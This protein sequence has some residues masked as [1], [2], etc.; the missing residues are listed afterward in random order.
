MIL[1]NLLNITSTMHAKRRNALASCVYSL[2]TGSM[3]TVTNIGR[4][5]DSSA[6]EK[7][8]IKQADRLLSNR[9]LYQE[10]HAIYQA[11]IQQCIG[12]NK[13]PIILLDWS[14]LDEC[15]RHFL[16]RATL[17]S[18][19]RGLCLY[20]E[21]HSMKTKEK[22]KTHTDFLKKLKQLLPKHCRP[23]IVSDA[24]FKNP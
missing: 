2:L 5:V 1:K 9:N 18:H 20:E 22:P 17:A 10:R 7:H 16:L 8:K 3:A 19:G 15:K 6:Y 21:V 23:I 13:Q 11:L 12:E 24:G 4:G 14:D